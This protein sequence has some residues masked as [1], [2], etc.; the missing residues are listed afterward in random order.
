MQ[1]YDFLFCMYE[2]EQPWAQKEREKSQQFAKRKRREF[3]KTANLILSS[4]YKKWGKTEMYSSRVYY[5]KG[6]KNGDTR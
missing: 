3:F 1:G 2:G 6:W 4:S 5:W